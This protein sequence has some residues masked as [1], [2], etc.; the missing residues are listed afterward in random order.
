MQHF[1]VYLSIHKIP[2]SIFTYFF[3]FNFTFY[4]CNFFFSL[5]LSLKPFTNMIFTVDKKFQSTLISQLLNNSSC[6]D[7]NFLFLSYSKTFFFPLMKPTFSDVI[8]IHYLTLYKW[9]KWPDRDE[10]WRDMRRKKIMTCNS[11]P[12]SIVAIKHYQSRDYA[13]FFLF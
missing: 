6:W 9:R 12:S 1:S 7:S 4:L 2:T 13:N 5:S 8:L 3:Q 10:K 11:N